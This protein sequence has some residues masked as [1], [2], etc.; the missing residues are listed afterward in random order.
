[1]T[2]APE[3]LCHRQGC[4]AGEVQMTDKVVVHMNGWSRQYCSLACASAALTE[5]A[6]MQARFRHELYWGPQL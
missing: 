6:Q 4:P 1:M 2:T 3:Q 5:L